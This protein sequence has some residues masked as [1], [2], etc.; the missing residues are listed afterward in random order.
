MTQV[1]STNEKIKQLREQMTS[2]HIAAYIVPSADPHLSEYLPEHWQAREWLSGFTGSAG[3][4]VVTEEE[5]GLW[6]DA[7]YW[8]QAEKELQGTDIAVKKLTSEPE[9]NYISWLTHK[10]NSNDIVSIDGRAL[11][12]SQFN[13]LST[14]LREYDIALHTIK[15]LITP[16]W[17]DRP[18]L[19]NA[20]IYAMED[21][22]NA[23][24]RKDKITKVSGYLNE[25]GIDGHFISSLDDIAWILNFRGQDVDYNPVF[26]AHL[27]IAN[28]KTTTIFIDDEKVT[29]EVRELLDQ[30]RIEIR[31][32]EDTGRF[33][34][35]LEINRIL[36]DPA[37]VTIYHGHAIADNVEIVEEINPS[38][39]FKARKEPNEID[40]IRNAMKKDGIALSHFFAWLEKALA[41][42]EA[43][44]ELTIDEKITQF[45]AQQDGFN[46][47]SFPTIAGFNAN[48]ALPHYRATENDYADIQGN[49]L[50]LIDSG[51]QYNDGTTDI[52]RV[53]PVGDMT[54]E[55][56]F[57]YTLV[58]KSHIA[59]AEAA[60]PEGIAAPL[61]DPIAR[62]PLWQHQL[63]YR[64][65]TGHGVGFA[66][67]VHEGPQSITH[68]API[69]ANVGMYEG[70]VTS[71]EPGLYRE[72]EWGIRIENL[73]VNV[74]A[75][76]DEYSYGKF[77][78]FENLT[79]CPIDTRC[80]LVDLLDASERK[81]LNAYHVQVRTALESELEGDAK[82]WL[83]QRTEAI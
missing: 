61:L 60:F 68:Y 71:N 2:H 45:R 62:Q 15:D 82:A 72:E 58:L 32:Y 20:P 13:S 39:L 31:P 6:V 36:I 25:H 11:S 63:D 40:H 74:Y 48:G 56:K 28:D 57:D 4:L 70:M 29:A 42:H 27:Y 30:E 19:P 7:R 73:V 81:W 47:P 3:T 38:T 9:S 12:L 75:G 23:L 55:Q 1:R 80:I 37:R 53:V 8:I 83:I 54:E 49:G 18:P 33:L 50:L 22:L 78:K 26:L 59:L 64:H 69:S 14:A 51:G 24:S 52:T 79:L 34:A 10:L 5:A 16:I 41:N 76:G 67:N 77:L 46:G 17:S 66:L 44:S 35:Q 65:G 21:G 43:I